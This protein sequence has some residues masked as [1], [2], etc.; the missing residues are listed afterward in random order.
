VVVVRNLILVA[1][2]SA[3]TPARAQSER[4][5]A[6]EEFAAGEAAF[7]AGETEV[8]L[9]HFRRALVLAPHDAVRF[10]LAICLERLGHAEEALREYEIVAAS[11]DVDDDTRS[12][13]SV[14]ATALRESMP[15]A[16]EPAPIASAPET[17]PPSTTPPPAPESSGLGGWSWLGIPLATVGAIGFGVFGA[18]A[19]SIHGQCDPLC[20]DRTATDGELMRDLANVSLGVFG[21]GAIFVTLDLVILAGEGS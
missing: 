7:A 12:R 3:S 1:A 6:G 18:L 20:D 17:R 11:A 5:L 16:E 21:L 4:A 9:A 15:V 19:L 13:A 10:N 2:F 8:A 14:L